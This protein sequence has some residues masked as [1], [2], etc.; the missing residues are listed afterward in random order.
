MIT[1]PQIYICSLDFSGKNCAGPRFIV[2]RHG[3][4]GMMSFPGL[5]F[6]GVKGQIPPLN[7]I[8]WMRSVMSFSYFEGITD[9]FFGIRISDIYRNQLIRG[10]LSPFQ[11]DSWIPW[12]LSWLA[13]QYSIRPQPPMPRPATRLSSLRPMAPMAPVLL[14]GY[15]ATMRRN[16]NGAGA[17]QRSAAEVHPYKMPKGTQGTPAVL[18]A[19]SL[20]IFFRRI[21]KRKTL[22]KSRDSKKTKRKSLFNLFFEVCKPAHLW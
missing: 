15:D 13:I 22:Y 7:W 10:S 3:C 19:S 17:V 2:H 11:V 9:V 1:G 18:V 21:E 20:E 8:N 12:L 6:L 14:G 4:F 16:S 5:V